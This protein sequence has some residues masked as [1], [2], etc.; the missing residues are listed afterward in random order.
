MTDDYFAFYN[1]IDYYVR[2]YMNNVKVR[3]LLALKDGKD[4]NMVLDIDDD[5]V[6]HNFDGVIYSQIESINRKVQI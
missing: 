6:R 5:D 3:N 2:I 1:E 4:R